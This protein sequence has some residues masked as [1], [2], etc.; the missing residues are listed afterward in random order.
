VLVRGGG[1]VPGLTHLDLDLLFARAGADYQVRVLRSPA[2]D[3]Q[4]VTFARP[5]NDLELENFI[6]KVGRFTTRTR[7]ID[8]PPVAAAKMFGGQLFDAVFAGTVGE[9]LRRSLDRAQDEQ[10]ALRLRLRLTDCSELADLPWE[11]LYDRTD[12]S[13]LAL[14]D[15]TPVI[16]YVQLPFQQ[17]PVH[18]TLPL[19]VLVIRSEPVDAPQLDLESE[20]AQVSAALGDL[21]SAE[22]A[23]CR[24]AIRL[25]PALANGH[26]ALGAILIRTKRI[27]EGEAAL[28]EGIRLDPTLAGAHAT[29]GAFLHTSKRF[30]EAEA[31]LQEAIR[32]D[33]TLAAAHANLGGTL[34]SLKRYAQAEAPSREAIRLDPT[35]AVAHANLGST[36]DRLDRP[37]EAEAACR[38]AIRLDPALAGA[39]F[40]LSSAL[41]VLGRNQEAETAYREAIRLNPVYGSA[42]YKLRRAASRAQGWSRKNSSQ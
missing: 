32:L 27:Q 17:R 13:F 6:L 1:Y 10:S 2:G 21:T 31:A 33:P 42:Q 39:Y 3:G 36:L 12:D 40:S 37:Q 35:L 4:S 8:A 22:E 38:E 34:L 41:L 28:R 15:R 16:R 26:V 25:D 9:C 11:L 23:A 19:R 14:S 20:W 18:V 29:L 30:T 5:F 7:R 24:E